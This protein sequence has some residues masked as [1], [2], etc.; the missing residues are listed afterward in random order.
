MMLLMI[1]VEFLFSH[2]NNLD[3]PFKALYKVLLFVNI[4][5]LQHFLGFLGNMRWQPH[6]L[7][8]LA[9]QSLINNIALKQNQNQQPFMNGKM[10]FFQ[11]VS[12][13]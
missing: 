11:E 7:N 6:P 10:F 9:N 2:I 5:V 1:F 13:D 8:K 12:K 4:G 3:P